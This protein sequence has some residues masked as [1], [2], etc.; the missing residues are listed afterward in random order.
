LTLSTGPA[1]GLLEDGAAGEGHLN[2]L[3]R[4]WRGLDG[5]IQPTVKSRVAAL[6]TSG[7]VNGDCYLLTATA[8]IHK[9]ARWTTRLPTAAWE[10]YTPKD[11]WYVWSTADQ[12][13]YRFKGT[14]WAE[15]T[16]GGGTVPPQSIIVACGDELSVVT[17]GTAK[18]TF[19]MPFAFNLTLIKA[20]LNVAQ[21]SGSLFTIDVKENGVSVFSTKPTFNNGS[22]TTV[23]ATTPAVLS[24]LSLAA[25]AEITVDVTLIGDATA[26][27]LKVTL[28]GTPG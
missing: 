10:Y 2:E 15:E 28:I 21:T 5:L 22:K 9:I 3:L 17:A 11:G 14:A 6:P 1:L 4:Q 23:G 25:D 19:R 24:D 7:Q 20:S 18:V 8:N 16:A 26:K 13:G 27:G 12:K